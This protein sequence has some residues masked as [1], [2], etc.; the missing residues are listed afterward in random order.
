MII[1]IVVDSFSLHEDNGL[2]FYY[3]VWILIQDRES[4][5]L[6]DSL[7]KD[8]LYHKFKNKNISLNKNQNKW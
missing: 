2:F 5:F 1:T 6:L 3:L 4:Y 8:N 7:V